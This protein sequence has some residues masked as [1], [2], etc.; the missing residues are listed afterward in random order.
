MSKSKFTY[1]LIMDAVKRFEAG[2]AVLDI[3]REVGVSMAT[4]Y[5]W[6]TK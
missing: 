6:R 1:S 4:F 2:F 5:K 3:C